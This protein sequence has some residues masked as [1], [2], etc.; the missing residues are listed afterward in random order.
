MKR[1]WNWLVSPFMAVKIRSYIKRLRFALKQIE[2]HPEEGPIEPD[3]TYIKEIIV[4]LIRYYRDDSD[5]LA[6]GTPEIKLNKFL[7]TPTTEFHRKEL[8]QARTLSHWNQYKHIEG[9]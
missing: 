6:E 7:R 1:I 4:W 5:A 2:R 8:I 3:R 9:Y